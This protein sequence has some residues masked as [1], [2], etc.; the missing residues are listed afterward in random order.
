MIGVILVSIKCLE[1]SFDF[2]AMNSV[3]MT[4]SNGEQQAY[5]HKRHLCIVIMC[6]LEGYSVF[7]VF[8]V[9]KIKTKGVYIKFIDTPA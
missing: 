9:S 7:I 5:L 2:N 1:A 4:T 3:V 6:I 8:D